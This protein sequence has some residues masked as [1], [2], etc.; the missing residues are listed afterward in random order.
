MP[1]D[2][3]AVLLGYSALT[4]LDLGIAKFDDPAG[5][6][7][8]HVIVVLAAVQFEHRMAGRRLA[9]LERM[10]G[11]QT[12]RLE[13]G[14][15]AIHRREADFL[16]LFPKPI[17]YL[18]GTHVLAFL[19]LGLENLQDFQPRHGYLEPGFFKVGVFHVAS[20]R[21][22][23]LRVVAP[24]IQ[25]RRV[26]WDNTGA[27]SR[28]E[29]NGTPL[30]MQTKTILVLACLLLGGCGVADFRLAFP[31]VYRI[32]IPQGNVIDQ[33]MVDQLQPGMTKRQVRFVMGTP[34]VVDTFDQERWD[35]VYSIEKK[36]E[37]RREEHLSLFFE[38]DLLVSISGDFAP[39][40]A[41]PAATAEPDQ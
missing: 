28:L 5:L 25:T 15:H 8:H 31:G 18:L 13:L 24:G 7:A 6:D 22:G 33:E 29:D 9:R 16:A 17:V 12:G 10:P 19:G 3:E 40:S 35:Y 26:L 23:P 1:H 39:G 27:G 32:D 30:L 21:E 2:L 41:A 14:E 36:R 20:S 37:P 4:A 11:Y 38:N 34:L